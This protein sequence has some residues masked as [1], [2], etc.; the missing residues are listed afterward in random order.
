MDNKIFEKL[1]NKI[2]K[3]NKG[4]L[5]PKA[6]FE[7]FCYFFGAIDVKKFPF[8]YIRLLSILLISQKL[9]KIK[10]QQKS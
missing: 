7:D 9:L 4:Q 8:N 3:F 2:Q 5:K 1:R 10:K 6:L